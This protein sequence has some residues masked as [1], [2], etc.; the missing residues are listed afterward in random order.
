MS[1]YVVFKIAFGVDI[2]RSDVVV[3]RVR[4]SSEREAVALA[5]GVKEPMP[6]TVKWIDEEV[7]DF[8]FYAV[9]AESRFG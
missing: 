6:T 4:A 3:G 1:E 8:Q 5:T 9:N 2:L 7:Y